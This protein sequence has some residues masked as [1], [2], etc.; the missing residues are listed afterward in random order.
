MNKPTSVFFYRIILPVF[1][2]SICSFSFG[3]KHK[4]HDEHKSHDHHKH[5]FEMLKKLRYN[6]D[7]G[8]KHIYGT[9]ESIVPKPGG[10]AVGK[11]LGMQTV[12]NILLPSGKILMTS[13]S[14][15]RNL[16]PIQYYP[17]VQDP[18][19]GEGL[20][21]RRYDPFHNSKISDYYELIN[22]T[23]IFNPED[24]TFYRI[25]SAYPVAD[26]QEKDHF[27]PSDMF[28]TGHIHMP[29]GNPFFVGGTQYYYPYRTGTRASYIFDWRKELTIDWQYVDWRDKP[30]V[31]N[32]PWIYSG[33]MKRGRWYPT[34]TPLLD[35]RFVLTSGFVGFDKGFPEM[36]Q[37]EINNFVEFFDYNVFDKNNP[38]KAW[39]WVDVKHLENSPFST[40]LPNKNRILNICYDMIYLKAWGH[41]IDEP[42]FIP[43]CHIPERGKIDFDFDAF[44]LYPH[45]YLFDGNKIYL[46]REGEWV[47]LRTPNTE[48]MRR[49]IFT[50]WM[51]IHGSADKPTIKFRRGPDRKDTITSYGTSYLDPNTNMITIL[52]GQE[53][54]AGTMLPLGS[55]TPDRFAGGRGSRR[56]ER[57]D[58]NANGGEGD[59]SEV[60]LDYLGEHAQ[61]N[62]TMHFAIIL[63]TREILIING[64]NY[65]FYGGVKYPILLTPVFEDGVFKDYKHKR[66][67]EA[68]EPR[69]YHNNAMLLP[70]G[71]IFISGG[72]SGRATVGLEDKVKAE[73]YQTAGQPLPNSDLV[74]L[75]IYFLT[76]GQ[77]ARRQKGSNNTPIENWTAEYFSPPYLYI[78]HDR[79]PND[80]CERRVSIDTIT[81]PRSRS[82]QY[83]STIDGKDY[84]LFHSNREYKIGLGGSFPRNKFDGNESLVLLKLPSVTH[85][86]QWG[87]LFVELVID[88]IEGNNLIIKTPDA[89]ENNIPPGYYMLFYVDS[90]GK[91]SISQMVRFDD[92]A[93]SP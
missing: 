9:W 90:A 6:S 55:D 32:D 22:N 16:K 84:Y 78:D 23:A 38:Q 58:L 49:T 72:N 7:H 52:G 93:M 20:F 91:P 45:N 76:D 64:G 68:V 53:A 36:Y 48:F 12:H 73:Y 17:E 44:K 47:S 18:A 27:I 54:S 79:R 85:G 33:T 66:M 43:P 92:K 30:Q 50:Y 42:G 11:S 29:D 61:D 81:T 88:K 69:L 10:G 25:H 77:M 63:P 21:D 82:V 26:S 80:M 83:K 62:R 75:D 89:K 31:K 8:E 70:D 41:D 67:A 13:G 24:S 28:C 57:F 1:C 39:R 14:S 3:Q 51:D 35:G 74:E 59:W 71:R 15:W 87:Q 2:L 5:S 60:D 4:G 37:F 86:G 46:S 40:P 56:M 65:D 19:G 34:V